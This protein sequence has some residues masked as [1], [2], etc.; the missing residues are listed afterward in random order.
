MY[1]ERARG[2]GGLRGQHIARKG[3]A[4]EGDQGGEERRGPEPRVGARG[5]GVRGTRE[6]EEE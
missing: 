3:E 5:R 2:K 6:S 4:V 1:R